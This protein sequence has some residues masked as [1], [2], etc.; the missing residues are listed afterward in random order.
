MTNSKHHSSP[1]LPPRYSSRLFRSS[2]ATC[3]SVAGA[4]R[5]GLWGCAFVAL[6]VLLT[7]LNYWRN[8]VQGWRRTADMT[9]VFGAAVYHAYCCVV[10]CQDPLVQVLYALFVANS[11]FCYLQARKAPNHD[12]S[13]AWHCGL[14]LL[15]NAA[16]L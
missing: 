3:F 1:V 15:G 4:L 14:H 11:G 9:A 13:T 16:N 6:I 5:S 8:P 7:S 10:Q 2:F 12:A